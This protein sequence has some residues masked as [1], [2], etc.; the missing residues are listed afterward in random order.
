MTTEQ[1]TATAFVYLM[2]HPTSGAYK[3]GLSVNPSQRVGTIAPRSAGIVLVGTIPTAEP[4]WLEKILHGAFSHRRIR[5]EW[6]RMDETDTHLFLSIPA[7]DR[8]EDLPHAIRGMWAVNE[9]R[10]FE[11]GESHLAGELELPGVSSGREC[12]LP[13]P[14]KSHAV[15]MDWDD[16]NRKALNVAAANCQLS[17]ATFVRVAM[18]ML[19]AGKAPTVDAV[20]VEADKLFARLPPK[21]KPR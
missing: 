20:G 8:W 15:R 5:N 14:K 4:V 2:H 12:R 6:F 17:V 3:I 11:F 10:E 19:V 18:E 16:E 21:K 1:A 9:A 13:K 7:A